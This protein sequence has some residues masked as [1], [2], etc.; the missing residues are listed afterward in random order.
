MKK[1]KKK[2]NTKTKKILI[3]TNKNLRNSINKGKK[4]D[5]IYTYNFSGKNL[6]YTNNSQIKQAIQKL[7][8]KDNPNLDLSNSSFEGQ[9]KIKKEK[10]DKNPKSLFKINKRNK[11]SKC[12]KYY[13]Y[14]KHI[15]NINII[16]KTSRNIYIN[17]KGNNNFCEISPRNKNSK[18]LFNVLIDLTKLIDN[19]IFYKDKSKKTFRFSK[20][21][22]KIINN[23]ININNFSK[24]FFIIPKPKFYNK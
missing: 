7:P 18:F 10:K 16:E 15:S 5:I 21:S 19:N 12:K 1:K 13:S 11:F 2:N 9:I 17:K 3:K 4:R 6:S 20:S 8:K 14:E 22:K 24:D 23:N